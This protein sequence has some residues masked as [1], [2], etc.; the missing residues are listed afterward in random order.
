MSE[1]ERAGVTALEHVAIATRDA[2]A[3]AALL[4]G[5]LGAVRGDEELLENGALRV[6]F[7]K[8][9]PVTLELLEPRSADHTVAKFLETRGPGLH[10]VSFAVGD[11]AAALESCRDEGLRL[12]DET[13]R[14]GAHGTRVAF[15]HPKSLGGVLVELC[16]RPAGTPPR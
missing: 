6:L 13:P 4:A 2:D 15:V 14:A 11:I 8:L 16:Q 10:H 1:L 12:I 5:A 3:L 9:G 7:V